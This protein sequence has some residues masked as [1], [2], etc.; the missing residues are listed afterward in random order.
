MYVIVIFLLRNLILDLF[1]VVLAEV[2]V[3]IA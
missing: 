3:D 2:D 1:T